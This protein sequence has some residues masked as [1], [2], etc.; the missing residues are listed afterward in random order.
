MNRPTFATF[1][2][3]LTFLVQACE[4]KRFD[5]IADAC[6]ENPDGPFVDELPSDREYR[7]RAA[8]A[9]AKRHAMSPL[10]ELYAGREFPADQDRVLLGGHGRELGHLHVVF[11]STSR[12]WQLRELFICR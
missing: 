11:N 9:L 10:T 5:E 6:E 12:G 8:E 4:A 1:A 3:A 7:I 2:E